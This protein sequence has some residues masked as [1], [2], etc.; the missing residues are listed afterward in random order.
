MVEYNAA[1]QEIRLMPA[2]LTVSALITRFVV[3]PE[4]E[5]PG[6]Q[7]TLSEAPAKD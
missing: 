7:K 2:V 6:F 3:T 1:R 5:L 4:S